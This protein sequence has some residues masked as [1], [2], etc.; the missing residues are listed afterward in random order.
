MIISA[1]QISLQL[2]SLRRLRDPDRM[3]AAAANAGYRSVELLASNLVAPKSTSERLAAYGL[4]APSAHIGLWALQSRFSQTIEACRKI[5]IEDLIVSSVPR[6]RRYAGERYWRHLGTKLAGL[7]LQIRELTGIRLGY[8][9]H[10]FEFR[11]LPSGRTPM[12]SLL[13]ADQLGMLRWQIDVGWVSQAG[14]DVYRW[15]DYGRGRLCSIHVKDPSVQFG[16]LWPLCMGA[17]VSRVIVE[18]DDPD[19]PEAMCRRSLDTILAINR[20]DQVCS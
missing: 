12:E 16:S 7:A 8:H 4:E 11:L 14:Q 10:G 13:E 19:E 6:W 17:G 20:T 3:I 1:N 15:L 18:L 2:H 5:G 9:N